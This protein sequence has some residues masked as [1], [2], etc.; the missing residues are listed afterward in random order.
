MRRN[1]LILMLLS[2]LPL[3]GWA[4]DIQYSWT[5][6]APSI[7]Y[8]DT[9]TLSVKLGTEDV[10]EDKYVVTY[11]HDNNGSVGEAITGALSKQDVG[12]YWVKV[13]A[14]NTQTTWEGEIVKSFKI[15][16]GTITVKVKNADFFVKAYKAADPSNGSIAY[17]TT[18]VPITFSKTPNGETIANSVNTGAVTYSYGSNQNA[19]FDKDGAN[20]LTTGD[21][22]YKISF[23]GITLKE[24]AEKN[25][26]LVWE[27]RY[28]KIKQIV[29]DVTSE[30]DGTTAN[31]TGFRVTSDYESATPFDYSADHQAPNYTVVWKYGTTADA[32]MTLTAGTDFI[33]NYKNTTL[34]TD[35]A[36]TAIDAGAYTTTFAS[37]SK[38]N[39]VAN[40][41]ANNNKLGDFTISK[42]ALTIMVI[43]RTKTFDGTPF[44][45]TGDGVQFYVTGWVT[46][47]LSATIANNY[48]SVNSSDVSALKKDAAEYAVHATLDNNATYKRGGTNVNAKVIDNYEPN[49]SVPTNWTIEKMAFSVTPKAQAKGY[50]AA[51]PDLTATDAL[52]IPVLAEDDPA[53]TDVDETVTAGA[54]T[55]DEATT[56]KSA[57]KLAWG[58]ENPEAAEG[59]QVTLN[60]NSPIGTYNKGI[61]LTKLPDDNTNGN[62]TDKISDAQRAVLKNYEI[63]LNNA[64]LTINGANFTIIPL[65]AATEYGKAIAPSAVAFNEANQPIAINESAVAYEY[66]QGTT[67]L[68]AA[69]TAVGSYT[70]KIVENDKI[71]KGNYVGGEITYQ[72]GNFNITKKA[73][74]LTVANLSLHKG[75]TRTTLRKYAKL[76]NENGVLDG[77]TIEYEF[78]FQAGTNNLQFGNVGTDHKI[79]SDAGT[80]AGSIKATLKNGTNNNGNYDITFTPGNLTILSTYALFIDEADTQVEDKIVDAALTCTGDATIKYTVTLSDRELKKDQ[81]NVMVLPFDVKPFDFCNDIECYAVFNT[82]KSASGENVKFGLWT[83]T[84]PANQPFL[85]KP[86][87][88]VK[89]ETYDADTETYTYVEFDDVVIKNSSTTQS[90]GDA[91]FIGT[92]KT[93][94]IPAAETGYSNW[95]MQGGKFENIGSDTPDLGFT[96]AYLLLK[97]T[98]EARITV[99]EADGSTTAISG[100]TADGV[101]VEADGWYN[102]NGVKMQAAPT[103]KGIYIRNGKKIIVK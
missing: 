23:S 100:I 39:F 74:T 11:F 88:N 29:F 40:A 51:M 41:T 34:S 103:Q 31:A 9:Q 79:T 4:A 99:E 5:V 89:F 8:G 86:V 47:D 92:Y 3:A 45:S 19:N 91:K 72:T 69:P 21:N 87:D 32:K 84:I 97:T 83:Q 10:D 54:I 95:A 77:E 52:V 96:R 48:L 63:T 1:F 60:Q 59:E 33:L 15:N 7:T 56:I 76:T 55:T 16:K 81:W 78:D 62:G 13:T 18:D 94:Q 20:P 2:L 90:V 37:K 70:V 25:Y 64:T 43:P 98:S 65:V 67:K 93:L 61:L 50:S 26:N 17:N 102:L 30:W 6:T 44:N 73:L 101:A 38:A 42:G 49:V 85:V 71:A 80:Y 68:S 66:Y 53:T 22:G 82:L 46:K 58:V 35:A 36:T 57:L 75:D 27:D 28:M 24:S 14:S 12:D